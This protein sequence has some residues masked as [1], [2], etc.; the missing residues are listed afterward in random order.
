MWDFLAL[1]TNVINFVTHY[2]HSQMNKYKFVFLLLFVA[3]VARP[4]H[5][6][7]RS[8]SLFHAY[9]VVG[10]TVN[11]IEGDYL[12]GFK[13]W[14]FTGGVGTEVRLSDNGRWK[15]SMEADF[16]QRGVRE[17]NRNS[18]IPYLVD[19]TLNYI[20]IGLMG[21]FVDPFGGIMLGVG[22]TYS[23]LVQ[24]PH[25]TLSFNPE[26]VVPDTTDMTFL[27][28]DLA[29]AGSLRFP[30]WR[31]LKLDLHIQYSLIPIKKD[32]TFVENRRLNDPAPLVTVND[33]KNFSVALRLLYVF[34]E[35]DRKAAPLGKKN[36]RK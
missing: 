36:K 24:Q 13:K 32:W 6:Q 15:L 21:H 34:G 2:W 12:K 1:L 19:L 33:C 9:P 16:S 5:A 23:R 20:D 27:K 8:E 22:L 28:N 3:V 10:V 7:F 26:Y 17:T 4:S 25:G 30:L 14:G 29:I 11:Q 35:G 31:G 18:Q